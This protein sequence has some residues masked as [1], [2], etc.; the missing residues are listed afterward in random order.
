MRRRL[1]DNLARRKG[2]TLPDGLPAFDPDYE[3]DRL[4]VHVRR[5]LDMDR[6]YRMMEDRRPVSG[7][8][9]AGRSEF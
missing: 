8:V 2:V 1:L 3:Y 9:P 7:P 4:A 6:V 5:H